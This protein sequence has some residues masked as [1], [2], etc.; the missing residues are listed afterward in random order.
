MRSR[1]SRRD[2]HCPGSLY[3][4]EKW[5]DTTTTSKT[6]RE[7]AMLMFLTRICFAA[8]PASVA[9]VACL[10]GFHAIRLGAFAVWTFVFYSP[11]L[12]ESCFRVLTPP[13]TPLS[14]RAK[15]VS[16][17]SLRRSKRCPYRGSFTRALSVERSADTC[18]TRYFRVGCRSIYCG[19]LFGLWGGDLCST[20][21]LTYL[22][23]TGR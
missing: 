16:V 20:L 9:Q 3:T 1:F 8:S 17:T 18:P 14:S 6:V 7:L 12:S 19:N 15:V 5:S 2:V 22:D 13:I 10:G 11:T 4:R 21:T 23:Q